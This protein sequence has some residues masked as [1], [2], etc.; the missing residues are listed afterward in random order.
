[1]TGLWRW[2]CIWYF[3]VSFWNNFWC[4][5]NSVL[6]PFQCFP[7]IFG[8]PSVCL[9]ILVNLNQNV[10][11]Q[12]WEGRVLK[13]YPVLLT[14]CFSFIL[15][16][17]TILDKP[18]TMEF[19]KYPPTLC[20]FFSFVILLSV[21][22]LRHEDMSQQL[23]YLLNRWGLSLACFKYEAI[24]LPSMSL[25]LRLSLVVGYLGLFDP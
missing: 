21:P 23:T 10:G 6:L 25:T 2:C 15:K 13:V 8:M 7:V 3:S 9:L 14:C 5:C 4:I 19:A 18:P 22:G 12:E 16:L 20:P 24:W 17:A 1:M 11:Q